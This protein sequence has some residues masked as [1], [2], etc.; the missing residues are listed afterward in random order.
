MTA[1][2]AQRIEAQSAALCLGR[3]HPHAEGGEEQPL[4]LRD[5]ARAGG[6]RDLIEL[7]V[8]H[9]PLAIDFGEAID[10]LSDGL[11]SR[12]M[13][14][15]A[16]GL[17]MGQYSITETRPSPICAGSRRTATSSCAR[18]ASRWSRSSTRPDGRRP[19]ARRAR[20]PGCARVRPRHS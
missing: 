12:K 19:T 8:T 10:Q 15:Q 20:P 2:P 3:P 17:V 5:V 14:G 1:G 16:L 13:I 7:F 18:C 4:G 11:R 9:S 6:H